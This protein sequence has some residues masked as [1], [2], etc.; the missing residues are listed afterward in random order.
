MQMR[1]LLPAQ[2]V[3]ALS[4]LEGQPRVPT[5]H[6]KPNPCI[7]IL[8]QCGFLQHTTVAK[9]QNRDVT[10]FQA[11]ADSVAPRLLDNLEIL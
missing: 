2:L 3:K 9:L 4:P 11:V 7:L 8:T 10:Y 6:Q 5:P 1:D